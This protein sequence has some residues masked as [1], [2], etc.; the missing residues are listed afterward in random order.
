MPKAKLLFTKYNNH[1][2]VKVENL[3]QLSVEEIKKIEAFVKLR[4]GI[5]DFN[6][7]SFSLQ[8]R[9]E[10][11][12][13]EKVVTNSTLSAVC[14]ENIKEIETK[15]RVGFGNYKG[16]L[17]SELPDSY[18]IWLKDNYSGYDKEKV[19]EELRNRKMI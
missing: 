13:F 16:M 9:L 10:F 4:N 11:G 12:E 7:Y 19:Q 14:K 17:Y 2:D 1:I 15:S 5:F 18:M 8:K 6:T 3:E